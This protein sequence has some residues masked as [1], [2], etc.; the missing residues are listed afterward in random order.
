MFP[1]GLLTVMTPSATVHC[2]GDLS[3]LD[4]HSFRFLPSNRMSASAGGVLVLTPGATTF[5]TGS[6]TSVSCGRGF[7][8]AVDGTGC[9]AVSGS[10]S[11]ASNESV[12]RGDD[13]MRMG[14]DCSKSRVRGSRAGRTRRQ[15][16]QIQAD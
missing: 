14:G 6:Q 12:K 1:D 16:A 8:V 10:T 2:A 15:Q 4:T 5:G 11:A 3:L 7:C 9:C 13:L